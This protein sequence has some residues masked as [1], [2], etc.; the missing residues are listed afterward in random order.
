MGAGLIGL[1][2]AVRALGTLPFGGRGGGGGAGGPGPDAFGYKWG[3]ET[4]SLLLRA[5]AEGHPATEAPRTP[6]EGLFSY[7]LSKLGLMSPTVT[8]NPDQLELQKLMLRQQG[9]QRAQDVGSIYKEAGDIAQRLGGKPASQFYQQEQALMPG[10]LAKI[11]PSVFEGIKTK[12]DLAEKAL[13]FKQQHEQDW[14]QVQQINEQIRQRTADLQAEKTNAMIAAQGAR[15]EAELTNAHV[16]L[17]R[18]AQGEER[19]QQEATANAQRGQLAM[20]MG[21]VKSSDPD[22]HSLGIQMMRSVAPNFKLQMPAAPAASAAAPS[23]FSWG[24]FFGHPAAPAA[25][26]LATPWGP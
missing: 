6:G 20:I 10:E 18:I 23:T 11:D 9:V 1:D 13:E 2:A 24:G 15:T 17:A 8:A 5:L 25:K 4:E 16:A 7:G 12:A 22:E 3:P 14:M 21:L 19:L 26:P